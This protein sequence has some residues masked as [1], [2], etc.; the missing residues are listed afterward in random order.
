MR[1]KLTLARLVIVAIIV[2]VF[3]FLC[4]RGTIS[5][6][7]LPAPTDILKSTWDLVQ[8]RGFWKDFERTALEVVVSCLI[9]M[10]IGLAVG[11]LCWRSKYAAEVLSPYLAAL[12]AIPTMIFYPVLLAIL[13]LGAAP[14]IVVTALMALV[15]VA[16]NTISGLGSISPT[17]LKLSQALDGSPTSRFS[18]VLLP[19]AIPLLMPGIKLGAIYALVGALAMEFILAD[20]GLGYSIGENYK[21]FDIQGMWA[22]ILLVLIIGAL[23]VGGLNRIEHTAR[24]DRA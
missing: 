4:D 7:V 6:L 1:L 2:A 15:P 18:R 5:A 24:R 9:G 8:T 20:R 12:Y 10:P 11:I 22:T 14:I 13:G 19:A 3:Q 17:L 21:N 16:I 23:F